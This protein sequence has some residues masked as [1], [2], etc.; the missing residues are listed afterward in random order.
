MLK[1]KLPKFENT[2]FSKRSYV[3]RTRQTTIFKYFAHNCAESDSRSQKRAIVS[4][5][6]TGPYCSGVSLAS[7][8]RTKQFLGRVIDRCAAGSLEAAKCS[9]GM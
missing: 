8:S 9:L 4:D 6:S 7:V 5:A 1:Y 3:Y 2:V